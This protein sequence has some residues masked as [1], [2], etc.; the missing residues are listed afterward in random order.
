METGTCYYILAPEKPCLGVRESTF[1]VVIS[2]SLILINKKLISYI[3]HLL[4]VFEYF[5]KIN[6]TKYILLRRS[7]PTCEH[8]VE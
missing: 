2:K 4:P 7:E 6:R 3:L 1:Y 8:I 5:L